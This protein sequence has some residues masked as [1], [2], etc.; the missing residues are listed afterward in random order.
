MRPVLEQPE[1]AEESVPLETLKNKGDSHL[2]GSRKTLPRGR[3]LNQITHLGSFQSAA[4]MISLFPLPQVGAASPQLRLIGII[5]CR[6]G[7]PRTQS[8]SSSG[9]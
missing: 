1:K 8:H 5:M 3:G 4:L 2:S 6:E 7:S 9:W